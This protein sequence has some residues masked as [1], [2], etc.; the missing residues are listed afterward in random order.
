MRMAAAFFFVKDD[1]TR[2]I[3]QVHTFFDPAD[4]Q[5]ALKTF[6]VSASKSFHLV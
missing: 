6:Q 2:L 4:C 3:L 1:H 5:S